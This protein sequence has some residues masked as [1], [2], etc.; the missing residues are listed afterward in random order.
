VARK[1]GLISLAVASR[2][3]VADWAE[4]FEDEAQR[5]AIEKADANQFTLRTLIG[6]GFILIGIAL[7]LWAGW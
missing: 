3:V 7:G 1:T 5:S 4:A 2:P 6:V